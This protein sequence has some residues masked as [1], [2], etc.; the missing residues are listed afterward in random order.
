MVDETAL[1]PNEFTTQQSLSP[2]FFEIS[3]GPLKLTPLKS[4][5][6]MTLPCPSAVY[7]SNDNSATKNHASSFKKGNAENLSHGHQFKIIESCLPYV[8]QFSSRNIRR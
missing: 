3:N 8:S 4:S 5:W 2:S 6:V 7:C 1:I